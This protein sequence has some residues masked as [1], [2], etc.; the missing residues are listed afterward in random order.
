[1]VMENSDDD[2]PIDSEFEY[3]DYSDYQESNHYPN[4]N[5]TLPNLGK[6]MFSSKFN[7]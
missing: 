6:T 5:T 4:F 1:M 2:E 7:H 3:S